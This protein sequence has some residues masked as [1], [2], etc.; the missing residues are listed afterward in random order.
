[1]GKAIENLCKYEDQ[2]IGCD[3]SAYTS[4]CHLSTIPG[5]ERS[6]EDASLKL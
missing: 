3:M 6:N 2:L 1:M 5:F 4:L